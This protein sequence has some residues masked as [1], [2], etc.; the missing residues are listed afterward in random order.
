MVLGIDAAPIVRYL[1]NRKAELGAAAHRDFAGDAGLEVFERIVDQIGENLLQPKAI[2]DD[3]R[4][5]VDPDRGLGFR[6]L[7]RHGRHNALDQLL[8]IDPDRLELAPSL[9]GEI[10]DRRYQ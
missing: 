10:K 9:A 8:G 7:M 6:S 3:V 5:R 2:A 4:Q 1:E